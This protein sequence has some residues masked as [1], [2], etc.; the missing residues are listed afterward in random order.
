M[1]RLAILIAAQLLAVMPS[2]A[3]NAVSLGYS[4][5]TTIVGP[6]RECSGGTLVYN[7]DGSFE[8]G[9]IWQYGGLVPP[10]YG[11]FGEAYDLTCGTVRCAAFWL[12]TL[13]GG[14]W[15]QDTDCYIWDGGL[16][17][18]PGLVVAVVSGVWF[19]NIPN[20]PAVGRN[21]VD[22]NV[23]VSGPFTIG[24]WTDCPLSSPYFFCAADE[25][26]PGG[27][28]WTCIA[29][30]IGYPTGWQHPSVVW[31]DARSIGCGL[32]F[33]QGVTPAASETWGAVKALFR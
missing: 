15:D 9:Y 11:A 3:S 20:W 6:Q 22:M 16:G 18:E 4:D 2:G 30:G 28:P 24:Y 10:Y 5:E 13:P 31:P 17:E 32:W 12:T 19:S 23:S 8:N 7:H 33:D 26:G 21:D 29:P 1:A 14:W 25:N 27:H